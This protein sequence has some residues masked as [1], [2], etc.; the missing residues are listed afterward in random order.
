MHLYKYI[1][2]Y[3]NISNYMQVYATLLQLYSKIC[4]KY[5]AGEPAT[6]VT[7][8]GALSGRGKEESSREERFV[9]VRM[10]MVMVMIIIIGNPAYSHQSDSHQ[11]GI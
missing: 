6:K 8:K 10:A 5:I 9:Q 3:T 4:K 11:V 7:R 1:K 2:L